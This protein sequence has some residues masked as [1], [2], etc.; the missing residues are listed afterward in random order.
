VEPASTQS[1]VIDTHIC[2]D[3][4]GHFKGPKGPTRI[5]GPQGRVFFRVLHLLNFSQVSCQHLQAL[6]FV[7]FV[8]FVH[9]V[10]FAVRVEEETSDLESAEAA[11]ASLPTVPILKLCCCAAVR[12]PNVQLKGHI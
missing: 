6:L 2:N 3:R 4:A 8:Q 10:H 5:Q 7:Q 9:F 1:E 11:K 12:K